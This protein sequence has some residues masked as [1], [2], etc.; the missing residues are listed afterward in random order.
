MCNK[1][2]FFLDIRKHVAINNQTVGN[3]NILSKYV[4]SMN[5]LFL[6]SLT[7]FFF[8]F[9]LLLLSAI[10]QIFNANAHYCI[11]LHSVLFRDVTARGVTGAELQGGAAAAEPSHVHICQLYSRCETLASLPCPPLP[12]TPASVNSDK[13]DRLRRA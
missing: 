4:Y 9:A 7:V 1:T 3:I 13:R 12:S 5:I 11:L 8:L 2:L 6:F 10:M